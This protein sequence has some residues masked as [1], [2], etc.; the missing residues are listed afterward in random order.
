MFVMFRHPGEWHWGCQVQL[1]WRWSGPL[2]RL[3]IPTGDQQGALTNLALLLR[4]N[5]YNN[6]AWNPIKL[7]FK[8]K[9]WFSTFWGCPWTW[10]LVLD[11]CRNAVMKTNLDVS[12]CFI[13]IWSCYVVLLGK[14]I[15]SRNKKQLVLIVS[16]ICDL[17][18]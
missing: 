17:I 15:F 9:L 12:K 16:Q 3:S 13:Y 10:Y 18:I 2:Q 5:I 6:M 11:F 1:R 8:W 14:C 4:A 7:G